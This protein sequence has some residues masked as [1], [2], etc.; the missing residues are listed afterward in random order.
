[1]LGRPSVPPLTRQRMAM[2]RIAEIAS[3]RGPGQLAEGSSA[4]GRCFNSGPDEQ[5]LAR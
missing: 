2:Q 5:D 1:M 4:Q 3:G